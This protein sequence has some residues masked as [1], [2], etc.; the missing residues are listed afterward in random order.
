M[1]G[2]ETPRLGPWEWTLHVLKSIPTRD[3]HHGSALMGGFH[4]MKKGAHLMMIIPAQTWRKGEEDFFHPFHNIAS[5]S[6]SQDKKE[7]GSQYLL[8]V[9]F[10]PRT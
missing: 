10:M 4:V 9:Y 2:W 7:N 3:L 1:L 5:G 6:I 8:N